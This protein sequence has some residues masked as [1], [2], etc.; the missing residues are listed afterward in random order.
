MRPS[1]LAPAPHVDALAEH[2]RVRRC[3]FVPISERDALTDDAIVA[4]GGAAVD[5]DANVVLDH[6]A[7]TDLGAERQLHTVVVSAVVN[8]CR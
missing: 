3:I 6:H 7:S 4:N 8:S 5:H 2:G 1:S